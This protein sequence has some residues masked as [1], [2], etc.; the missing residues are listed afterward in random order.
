[1]I[2]KGPR[3][4]ASRHI[5]GAYSNRWDKLVCR[6]VDDGVQVFEQGGEYLTLFAWMQK[7]GG[8]RTPVEARQKLLA[9]GGAVFEVPDTI[10]LVVESKFVPRVFMEQSYEKRL[11]VKDNFSLFMA[12]TFG[13]EKAEF[14]LRKYLVGCYPF[15]I[16]GSAESSN[17][18]QFWYV[19]SK[20]VCHDKLMLYG[21]DGHRDHEYGG[22]RR[23]KK[24]KGFS[25]RCLFGE[26]LLK[27]RKDGERI[28]VV[29]AEKTAVVCAAYFGKHI[30]LATGG[31]NNMPKSWVQ[32]DW[33]ILSDIDAWE[34]WNKRYPG[35]C[36]RWW[37]NYHGWECGA[38]ADMG[39][40][41]LDYLIRK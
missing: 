35:Q 32:P 41:V 33:T 22:G 15:K 13:K 7:Y 40:L 1:M 30:F 9:L 18:T 10:E 31:K 5:D 23:F 16:A 17:M 19:N 36:S 26:H 29:E 24:G 12:A 8:C 25:N 21:L 2:R 14:Y 37:K 28:F 6:M 27:D 34:E 11:Q 4:F 38:K 39:D 3:W 20:G